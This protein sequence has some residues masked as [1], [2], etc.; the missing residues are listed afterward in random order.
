MQTV[1]AWLPY[2]AHYIAYTRLAFF[3]MIFKTVNRN[4][5][6]QPFIRPEILSTHPFALFACYSAAL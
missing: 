2:K 6:A 4:D 3:M 1:S 5:M